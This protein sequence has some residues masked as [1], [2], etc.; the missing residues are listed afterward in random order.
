MYTVKQVVMK[1][2]KY[3]STSTEFNRIQLIEAYRTL[4]DCDKVKADKEIVKFLP[5]WHEG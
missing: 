4:T 2:I 5:E 1:A 3:Y